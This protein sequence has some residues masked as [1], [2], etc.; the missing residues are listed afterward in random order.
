MKTNQKEWK[1]SPYQRVKVAREQNPETGVD[2][3]A[4]YQ[5]NWTCRT[6]SGPRDIGV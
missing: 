5:M 1:S 6:R 2:P 4:H 3:Y